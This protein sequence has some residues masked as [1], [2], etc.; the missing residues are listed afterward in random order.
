ME[1]FLNLMNWHTIQSFLLSNTGLTINS[2]VTFALAL[3]TIFHY[4][5]F[6]PS[7]DVSRIQYL[8]INKRYVDIRITISNNS[9]S[10]EKNRDV[11][12]ELPDKT[13]L[14]A[15]PTIALKE[16]QVTETS[17]SLNLP[18]L[19]KAFQDYTNSDLTI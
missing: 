14:V 7:T 18:D 10:S 8:I 11:Y 17:V 16:I 5:R 2:I 3:L 13:Q 15:M 6:L 12:L 9:Q 1:N 4:Q 19:I